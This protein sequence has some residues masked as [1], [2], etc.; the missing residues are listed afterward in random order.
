[1]SVQKPN[2]TQLPNKFVDEYMS[3]V[4]PGA[5]MVY[6]VICRK[7]IGWQKETDEISLAQIIEMT[8]LSKSS[9]IR[10]VKKLEDLNLLKVVRSKKGRKSANCYE[11]NFDD[12]S[13]NIE[14]KSLTFDKVKDAFN[15]ATYEPS[16][17]KATVNG[18][19]DEPLNP[20]NGVTDRPQKAFNGVTDRP[21]TAFNGV[22]DRHTKE[23]VLN[24]ES[25]EIYA[26]SKD[27]ASYHAID[28]IFTE[29]SQAMTG[30]PY[31]RDAKEAR[32]IKLLEKRYNNNPEGFIKL[33]RKFYYMIT[34]LD[35][36]F[37]SAQ[38]FT[39]SA[40]NSLYNRVLSFQLSSDAKERAVREQENISDEERIFEKYK[41]CSDSDLDYLIK[42]GVLIREDADYIKSRHLEA[43]A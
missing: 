19:T 18:V 37:W 5:A 29:G 33:A 35:D 40:F 34:K 3:K 9:A 41:S 11:L 20:I 28:R 15:G 32:Q 22:T 12:F 25:K 16:G 27:T 42:T 38:P 1:M 24:K 17:K 10:G 31:Y 43:T 6:L 13:D 36:P 21:Q 39:P 2:Y 8:G 23:I 26:A 14:Q 30:E 4:T 7:T